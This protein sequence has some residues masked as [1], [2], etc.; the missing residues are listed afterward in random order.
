[1]YSID[2]R[3]KTINLYNKIKSLRKVAKLLE[4]S[5]STIQ[6]WTKNIFIKNKK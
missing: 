5:K 2:L 6:R 1:M 3:I 4:I